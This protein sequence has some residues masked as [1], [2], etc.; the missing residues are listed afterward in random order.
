[1]ITTLALL[2]QHI[3]T[4]LEQLPEQILPEVEMRS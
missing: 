1:M 3:L 2:K 4:T